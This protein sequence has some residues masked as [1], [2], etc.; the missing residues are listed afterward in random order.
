VRRSAF[1]R[2]LSLAALIGTALAI[3]TF[4]TRTRNDLVLRPETSKVVSVVPQSQ[5]VSKHLIDTVF[6]GRRIK[7]PAE[8]N[9]PANFGSIE[10]TSGFL[11]F[12]DLVATQGF[13]EAPWFVDKIKFWPD[14]GHPNIIGNP[15]YLAIPLA[16]GSESKEIK[17]DWGSRGG[18]THAIH[19]KVPGSGV[20]PPPP[21]LVACLAGPWTVSLQPMIP[22][23]EGF[24]STIRVSI[25]ERQKDF[26]YFVELQN[27]STLA[28]KVTRLEGTEPGYIFMDQFELGEKWEVWVHEARRVPLQLMAIRQ[29]WTSPSEYAW[30]FRDE[31]GN[32]V[33]RAQK[34]SGDPELGG[35][36]LTDSRFMA[37]QIADSW[38]DLQYDRSGSPNAT[39]S[40][41]LPNLTDLKHGDWVRA[42]GYVRERHART[43]LDRLTRPE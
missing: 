36:R 16:T 3:N 43:I 1:W 22:P 24:K 2:L 4:V 15:G 29:D 25:A 30:V 13:K 42:V 12:H 27:L 28:M 26:V 23:F 20:P 11:V 34:Y 37:L 19:A 17:I 10:K 18:T 14:E 9:V 38:V 6:F 5:M 7:Y 8:I 33:A 40:R 21:Y 31:A 35:A 41:A 32:D 39:Y